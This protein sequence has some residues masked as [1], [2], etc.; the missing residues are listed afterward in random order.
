MPHFPKPLPAFLSCSILV[1]LGGCSAKPE[2]DTPEARR[3][4][5]ESVADDH[6][7]ALVEFAAKNASVKASLESTKPLYVL[8][9]KIVTTSA[10]KDKRTLECSADMSVTV[11]DTKAS[12]EV[13]FTVQQAA[14][15]KMSVSVVP[16]QF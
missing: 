7:N 3:A 16:F 14:D 6:R 5:L 4:V 11:G 10:S 8:G 12:K 15:G 2:C 1:L 13:H 9:E